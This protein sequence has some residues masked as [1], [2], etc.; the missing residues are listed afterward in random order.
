MPPSAQHAL[1]M[2]EPDD[3]SE[4]GRLCCLISGS[5]MQAQLHNSQNVIYIPF[6]KD[7]G[8]KNVQRASCHIS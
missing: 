7:W 1:M 5:E 3:W 8:L 2:S 6:K 4:Q